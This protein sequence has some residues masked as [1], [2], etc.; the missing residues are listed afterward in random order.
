MGRPIGYATAHPDHP[1]A[2]SLV[3]H[4]LD[5]PTAPFVHTEDPASL[6]DRGIRETDDMAQKWKTIQS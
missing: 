2:T 3:Q 5:N 4:P 1:V 6:H